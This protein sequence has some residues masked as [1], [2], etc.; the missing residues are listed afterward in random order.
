MI[1]YEEPNSSFWVYLLGLGLHKVCAFIGLI[2]SAG[3][4]SASGARVWLMCDATARSGL[5][6]PVK[7][8][9]SVCTDMVRIWRTIS[10]I[11]C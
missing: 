11:F 9:P 4:R 7:R 6:L 5:Y 3:A 2:Y 8:R 10:S 1:C